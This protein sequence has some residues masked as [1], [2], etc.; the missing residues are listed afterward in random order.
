MLCKLVL[1]YASGALQNKGMKV[2]L[3]EKVS[4]S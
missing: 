4:L 2:I 1:P 3:I